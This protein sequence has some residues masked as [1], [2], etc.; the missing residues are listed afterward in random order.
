[1]KQTETQGMYLERFTAYKCLRVVASEGH[2]EECNG[3]EEKK[4]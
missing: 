2:T 3:Y 1:M 4:K